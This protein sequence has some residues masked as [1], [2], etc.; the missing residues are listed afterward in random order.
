MEPCPVCDRA[1]DE[2]H[3]LPP[4]VITKDLVRSFEGLAS[5]ADLQACAVCL[6]GFMHADQRC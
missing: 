3:S 1:V 4:E 2:L 5:P 6:N